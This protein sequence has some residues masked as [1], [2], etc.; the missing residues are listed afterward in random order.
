MKVGIITIQKCN[1]YGADLQAFALQRKLQLM[2]YDAENIDYLFYKNPG[3]KKTRR[4]APVF[5]LSIV[6]RIKEWLLPKINALKSLEHKRVSKQRERAFEEFFTKNVCT[7]RQYRTIDELYAKPP[8][9]D[10]Y[11]TGSD[12]VWN[13]RTG[14]SVEPYFLTFAPSGATKVSYASSFG[15][16]SLPS[17]AYYKYSKWLES[18]AAI[19]VRETSGA[20]I[21]SQFVGCVSPVTVC[22]PTLL[23]TA[24]E[25]SVVAK[26]LDG[27]EEGKYLL[28]YDLSVCPRLWDLARRWAKKLNVRIVR[29]CRSVGCEKREGVVNVETAGPGEFVGLV[30]YAAAVVTT[31]FHGTV[32]SVIFN[33]SFY[34]VIPRGMTN[35]ARISNLVDKLGISSRVVKESD[36]S[37][38]ELSEEIKDY[39]ESL[40]EFRS[41]SVSYL[42][43]AIG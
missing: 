21:A 36:C 41:N 28:V 11:V 39:N 8:K 2:G 12:Q 22:D 9:Y 38:V 4:S 17:I 20:R 18:Y 19:S 15:V 29:I 16:S 1:N 37:V 35:S 7:S 24:D 14:A 30:K 10:V 43:N 23:L 31:S 13:P 34:S 32:F 27:V 6:N 33:R 40:E 3:F 25:W 5:K 42:R 26:R